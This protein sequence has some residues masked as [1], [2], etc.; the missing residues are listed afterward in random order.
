MKGKTTNEPARDRWVAIDVGGANLKA[1]SA[2]G[3]ARTV[4]FEVWR[5]PREL[6]QAVRGL[7][8]SFTP[9]THVALTMTAELC[10]CFETKAEGVIAILD[11]VQLAVAER[12]IPMLIWGID[13]QFHHAD[14][15]RERPLLAAA[16]NWL[17]LAVATARLIA[18]ER[19]I[20]IDIGSTTTDLIPLDRGRVAARGRSDT[21]RLRTGE[22][23][24]A[25]VRRT[26]VCALATE[27]ALDDC[28]PIGLAAELFATTL[29]VFLILGDV[30]DDPTDLDTAD[31]R[32]A[33]AQAAR[34][35]LARM[36][37]ADR[38]TFSA[39]DATGLARSVECRLLDRLAQA[40]ERV[41]TATIG[42]PAVAVVSGSG[43]FLARRLAARVLDGDR[44]IISLAETWG[45]A[46]SVAACAWA[47]IKLAANEILENDGPHDH[48]DWKY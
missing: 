11:S 30:T 28:E 43:E 47:L 36:I 12:S 8:E 23:I 26:P 40:I 2:E 41:C 27:L 13:E 29:D 25:G 38:G 19:G 1:A 14:E 3:L 17:A 33:T 22:L 20:L 46:G 48:S 34:D 6:T 31:G 39:Q 21:D 32:P 16:A 24:Y 7:L 5:T 45:P 42:T 37:G 18:D 9:F 15:I 10:D 35:R 44:R 4:P